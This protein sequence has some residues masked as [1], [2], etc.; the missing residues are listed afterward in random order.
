MKTWWKLGFYISIITIVIWL[1][2]GGIWWK[3]IGLW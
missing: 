2:I 3:I 1:G